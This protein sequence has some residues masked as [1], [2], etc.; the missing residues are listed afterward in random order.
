MKLIDH[1]RLAG[2]KTV[3][4]DRSTSHDSPPDLGSVTV[5]DVTNVAE[6]GDGLGKTEWAI[7]DFP[8]V[9]P[10][11]PDTWLEYVTPQTYVVGTKEHTNAGAGDRVGCHGQAWSLESGGWFQYLTWYWEPRGARVA[12]PLRAGRISYVI[13]N[14]GQVVGGTSSPPPLGIMTDAERGKL[15][16]A[17]RIPITGGVASHIFGPA[18]GGF[19]GPIKRM[20]VDACRVIWMGMSLMHCKNVT[21]VDHT[22]PA[23]VAA[24]RRKAGKPVGVTYKTL[25]IDGMKEVLRTEGGVEKNGLKKALHICRG[26]FATYTDDKPLFGKITGTFWKPMHTRGN[27]TRGEVKKDY[28]VIAGGG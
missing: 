18:D 16:A 15:E 26:H 11:W 27:K 9:A 8:N 17:L 28:K 19:T 7:Q 4:S 14:S 25:V 2:A 12:P 23:K 1:L 3:Y 24:K 21:M 20:M 13:D 10:P 5:V 22:P 6:Y